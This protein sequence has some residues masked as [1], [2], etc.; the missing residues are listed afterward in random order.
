MATPFDTL[1]D[2]IRNATTN[3]A[4][5]VGSVRVDTSGGA[6]PTGSSTAANQ[7]LANT[8]LDT[9][10]SDLQTINSLTPSTY[11]Y[12]ALAYTGTD[13]TTVTYKLGGSGGTT[14]ATLTLAYSSSVLQSVTRS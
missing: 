4:G 14:V 3:Y 1:I 12:I 11:D 7:V 9:L 5:S 13:L 2:L 8:K 6:G 10:H